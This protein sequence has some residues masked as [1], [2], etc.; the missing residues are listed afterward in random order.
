MRF[1]CAF[2]HP[3][4]VEEIEISVELSAAECRAVKQMVREGDVHAE[5]KAA[6]FALKSAYQMAPRNYRHVD[7]VMVN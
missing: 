4:R 6:A 7:V 5:C 1:I 3:R 2:A